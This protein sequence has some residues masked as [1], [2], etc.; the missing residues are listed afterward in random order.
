[1][2]NKKRD[3]YEVLGISKSASEAEIKKAYRKLAKQYHPD[4]NKAADAVDKFKEVQEAYEI[5]SDPQKRANYDQFGHAAADSPFG[6]G[7]GGFGG[8]EGDLG[9]IFS[10]FFGGG[11]GGSTRRQSNRPQKGQDRFMQMRI[12]FMEAIFGKS[13]SITLTVDELCSQ[14]LGSGARSKDDIKVCETCRGSG[15]VT[16]SQQTPFG[17]FQQTAVCPTCRGTGK[18]ITHVCSKCHGEGYERKRQSVEVKIPAG[19]NTGQQLRVAHKGERGVNG[20]D[21]GDLYL[22]I[23]VSPHKYFVRR[24]K[25][26]HIEVPISAVDATLGCK[27]DVPTVY[28]DVNLTVPAG[29]QFGTKLRLKEKGVPDL[30]SGK[31]GDQ[32]VEVKIEIDKKLSRES[33][34][35]YEKLK[36][37]SGKDTAFT[38]FKNAFK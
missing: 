17:V 2:S 5:L 6:Q 35:L 29:T 9:D 7:F 3:Y 20:G 37:T 14:C 26:I 33:K 15:Q 22:E 36:A 11:F 34:E 27:I 25:D 4:M 18:Q 10:S 28:G 30:G 1:M 21:N 8:F 19:I 13:E 31:K 32:I 38:R 16:Q 12:D 23:L 24:G